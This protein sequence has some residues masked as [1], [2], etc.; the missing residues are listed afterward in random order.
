MNLDIRGDLLR[1]TLT[2]AFAGTYN[3]TKAD[4]DTTD[5]DSYNI[6]M[7]V[8]Y[9]LARNLWGFL[10]P[11][12]GIRGNYNKTNDRVY[13]MRNDEMIIMAV[14]SLSMPSEGQT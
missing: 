11:S 4:D 5:S 13:S 12:I 6:N 1:R 2:Y 8:Q 3:M 7:T 10:N 9:L 14:F